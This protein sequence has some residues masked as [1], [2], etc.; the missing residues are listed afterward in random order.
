MQSCRFKVWTQTTSS[1]FQR[2]AEE[3]SEILSNI[4]GYIVFNAIQMQVS[5]SLSLN[6]DNIKSIIPP[7]IK[8]S[9]LLEHV[10]SNE[11]FEEYM[12]NTHKISTEEFN[13]HCSLSRSGFWYHHWLAKVRSFY[14]QCF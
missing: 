5:E 14:C 10:F 13:Y 1:F 4:Y 11:L 7:A 2:K 8:T 6:G 9:T 12:K 3:E